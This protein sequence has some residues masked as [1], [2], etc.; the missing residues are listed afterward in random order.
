MD[1]EVRADRRTQ[2]R[3]KLVRE[4]AAYVE[5]IRQGYS[6]REACRIVGINLRTGKKWRNGHHA[7]GAGLKP[8]PGQ[9]LA[10]RQH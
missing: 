9:P 10:A 1:F 8:R 6:S 4:R 7:P 3:R 2:G 5:L